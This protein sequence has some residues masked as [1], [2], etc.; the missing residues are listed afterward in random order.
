MVKRWAWSTPLQATAAA[1]K[2]SHPMRIRFQIPMVIRNA[3]IAS[4]PELGML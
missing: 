3:H 1:A 4:H 2:V